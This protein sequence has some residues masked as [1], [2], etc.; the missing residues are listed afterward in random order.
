MSL[1]GLPTCSSQ[2]LHV[3]SYRRV[4]EKSGKRR[5]IP[6]TNVCDENSVDFLSIEIKSSFS[7]KTKTSSIV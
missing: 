3:D 5:F 7:K 2:L 4:M 1:D 6:T